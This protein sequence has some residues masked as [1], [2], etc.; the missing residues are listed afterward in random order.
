M[1]KDQEYKIYGRKRARQKKRLNNTYELSSYLNNNINLKNGYSYILDIGSGSGENSLYLSNI[2]PDSKIIACDIFLDG[3]YNLSSKIIERNLNNILIY[4]G[5]VNE[6][7]DSNKITN[8]F[9]SVWILFPDPW[10]KKKHFKRRLLNKNFMLKL[11]KF[12]KKN[13]SVHIAT[14]SQSYLRQIL[15]VIYNIKKYFLWINQNRISWEFD[16]NILPET[17]FYKKAIK[18]NRKPI[19]MVLKK[20]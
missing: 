4:N 5:N 7:L 15:S 18:Y 3:N 17:K 13:G 6:F 9:D 14:D 8:I 20:L 1:I 12:I 11:V 2:Y 10:P 16:V 19:Y